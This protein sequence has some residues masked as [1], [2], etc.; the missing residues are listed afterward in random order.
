MLGIRLRG[1][2]VKKRASE[3]ECKLITKDLLKSDEWSTRTKQMIGLSWLKERFCDKCTKGILISLNCTPRK[4]KI[5]YY[6]CPH[7]CSIHRRHPRERNWAATIVAHTYKGL[8]KREIQKA[9][10]PSFQFHIIHGKSFILV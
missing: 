8:Y 10:K 2:P 6:V 4:E 9:R 7:Y 3:D 5:R 1:K